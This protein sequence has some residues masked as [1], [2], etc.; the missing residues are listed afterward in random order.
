MGRLI[1]AVMELERKTPQQIHE[2]ERQKEIELNLRLARSRNSRLRSQAANR[3]GELA[4][5]TDMLLDLLR[6]PN[7]FVRQA[8]AGA[9]A[10]AALAEGRSDVI[11]PLMAAIDD[12]SD[13]V[14]SSAVLSLG[15]LKAEAS[16]DEIIPLLDDSNPFIVA[17]A[18]NALGRLGP[19]EVAERLV[20]Y[21]GNENRSVTI[22]ALRAVSFLAYAPAG[23]RVLELI[24]AEHAR[25]GNR[26]QALWNTLLYAA[27]SLG[28]RQAIPILID[29]AQHDVGLRS[30]AVEVLVALKAAEATPLL[31]KMLADPSNRLRERLVQLVVETD[32]REGLSA[33]RPMLHDP[34]HHIRRQAL[35]A[36][37]RFGDAVSLPAVRRICYH[38]PSPFIRCD[39]LPVLVQLAGPAAISDL[40]AL[41]DDLNTEVRRTVAVQLGGFDC[42][43]PTAR[44]AL[45]AMAENDPLEEV[46]LAAQEAWNVQCD[47]PVADELP[48]PPPP[49]LVP[50]DLVGELPQLRDLLA[51][52]QAALAAAPRG[53]STIE[54][55][56]AIQTLLA[57]LDLEH[58]QNDS[59]I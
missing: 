46:R 45:Q 16:R 53:E 18:I 2:A 13:Y 44:Q 29:I 33:I 47:R 32:Y 9:L 50:E 35:S 3:L 12:P 20:K 43:P 34:S 23:P 11:E 24:Q 15:R 21:I 54:I 51:R 38:D 26:D 27:G 36:V 1:S 8:A 57:A 7:T 41:K 58:S 59:Q 22:A 56:R 49:A 31:M 37:A 39:A 4:A 55:E 10:S 48:V 17:S 42:L 6:D 40:L 14:T 19:P 25:T 5:G 52:W 30:R 28:V